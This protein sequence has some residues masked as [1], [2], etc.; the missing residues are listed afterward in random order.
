MEKFQS[1]G[2]SS[3]P[4]K[5]RSKQAVCTSLSTISHSTWFAPLLKALA[6]DSKL[7]IVGGTVRDFFLGDE[8]ADID[9]AAALPPEESR[10]RLMAAGLRVIET[11]LKHG[12]ITT[13]LEKRNV[14]I[15]TFRHQSAALSGKHSEI[16]QDLAARDFTVN[17]MAFCVD[18]ETLLDPFDGEKDLGEGILRAVG[19]AQERFEEDALRIIRMVR[20][21]PCQALLIEEHTREAAKLL[22]PRLKTISIERIRVELEKMLM[23]AHP[24]DGFRTLRDLDLLQYTVN[25]LIP[26]VGFEQ[27]EFHIHDVFEHTLWVIERAP[28]VLTLRLAGLFH[29][30]AKPLT[31]TVDQ[32]GSRHFYRHENIGEE[33]TRAAMTRLR[34]SGELTDAVCKLVRYHMRPLDCG[35][36]AVRRLIRDLG[37]QFDAWRAFKMADAPPVIPQQEFAKDL[38]KFEQMVDD[39]Q[40]RLAEL[41]FRRL[42]INGHDLMNLGLEEGVLLGEVMQKLQEAVIEKPELN[43]REK[44]TKLAKEFIAQVKRD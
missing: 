1:P 31:L 43:S 23:S 39:E 18:S 9:L 14:E 22:A 37:P 8:T 33:I 35:P 27:N 28:K 17:A 36:A 34:F 7:H 20:L 32:D 44:L 38:L 5:L 4:R 13:V 12:T 15:T 26:T 24:A 19:V 16:T 2:N 10:R 30:I 3:L 25:E 41:D 40:R 29:D 6:K 21:G 11:G 42:A